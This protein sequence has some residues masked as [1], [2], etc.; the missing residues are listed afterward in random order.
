MRVVSF[1][2]APSQAMIS[3]AFSTIHQ[4]F[5][6]ETPGLLDFRPPASP[7]LA[8]VSL[9]V[10]FMP[11]S[12]PMNSS[13]RML[14]HFLGSSPP[15]ESISKTLDSRPPHPVYVHRHR[16]PT[17]SLLSRSC[18]ARKVGQVYIPSVNFVLMVPTI[19]LVAILQ[20]GTALTAAF[21]ASVAGSAFCTTVVFTTY[22]ATY[23]RA[24]G[25]PVS[26]HV[27]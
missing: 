19:L 24:C 23:A 21:G 3:G 26:G 25:V 22:L 9:V 27:L 7:I 11:V 6:R 20:S 8:S 12:V 1:L 5:E 17:H 2:P 14:N 4:V 18:T 15:F 13:K 10:S 16:L